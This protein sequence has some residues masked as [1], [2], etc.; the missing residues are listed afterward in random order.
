VCLGAGLLLAAGEAAAWVI[1]RPIGRDVARAVTALEAARIV[2]ARLEAFRA[3][4]APDAPDLV[5][6][7]CRIDQATARIRQ[8]LAEADAAVGTCVALRDART[9][10]GRLAAMGA[11]GRCIAAAADALDSAAHLLRWIEACP[12]SPARPEAVLRLREELDVAER[13]VSGP[14]DGA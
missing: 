7:A 14:V 6:M 3:A 2:V 1:A 4:L 5:P 8:R 11:E 12:W 9:R 13:L 10:T